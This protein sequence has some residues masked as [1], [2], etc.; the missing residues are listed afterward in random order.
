MKTILA[1]AVVLVS[2]IAFS[3]TPKVLAEPPKPVIVVD[4]YQVSHAQETWI[5][6]LEW[7]E[8]HGNVSAINPKDKDGTPSYYSF[9]FKPETLLSYGQK[10]GVINMTTTAGSTQFAKE[11]L[12]NYDI[13]LKVVKMM[14]KDKTVRWETQFPDCVKRHIGFPPKV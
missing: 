4:P 12:P 10:Y 2:V 9:Q 11:I 1:I 14:V 8:S 6:A 7:C 13:Q 3:V 5:R